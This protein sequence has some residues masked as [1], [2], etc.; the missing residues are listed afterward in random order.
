MTSGASGITVGQRYEIKGTSI[1]VTRLDV[2]SLPPVRAA[3]IAVAQSGGTT[4]YG[5]V[6]AAADLP[7]AVNGLGRLLDLV[8]LECELL[9]EPDLAALV[10]TSST[11]EVG[12]DYARDA[13]AERD[14]VY[15]R[16]GST[17][18][19]DE[20][21][22]RA[23]PVP[24]PPAQRLPLPLPPTRPATTTTTTTSPHCPPPPPRPIAGNGV[25]YAG[26]DL[27]WST[28]NASG[29]AVVDGGGRLLESATVRS[30]DDVAAWFAPHLDR[31]AVVAID[32][33]LIVHNPSGSRPVERALTRAFRHVDAGTYPSNRANPLFDPPRAATL[34]Q[35]FGWRATAQRPLPGGG[36]SARGGAVAV[37]T[38]PHPAMV[39]LFGLDRVIPYKPRPTRS[40]DDRRTALGTLMTHLEGLEPLA[41]ASSGRWSHLREAHRDAHR[42]VD[43]KRLEDELDG[44]FC[45]H[46]AWLWGTGSAALVA[47]GDDVDGFIVAPPPPHRA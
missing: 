8:G 32:A 38:Y 1:T 37:E 43:L 36:T 28:R 10:V 20:D 2:Q 16:W 33:P 35:R 25:R 46:L 6:K 42:A 23:R 14:Q 21:A 26:L 47:W 39:A 13:R 11:N 12:T 4:T 17:T 29:I 31:L 15:R 3:L 24:T 7:H 30:D 18:R 34:A 9:G 27:A 22:P 41:L 40:L 5:R 45:A 44:I 19:P